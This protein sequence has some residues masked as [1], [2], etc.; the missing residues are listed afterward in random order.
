MQISIEIVRILIN[1]SECKSAFLSLENQEACLFQVQPPQP[2]LRPRTWLQ[3]RIVIVP[4]S[5]MYRQE[6]I[7]RTSRFS[8][9][10][11]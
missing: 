2:R 1:K 10:F 5:T 3:E 4:V 11:R 8:R 9:V 7:A 6:I